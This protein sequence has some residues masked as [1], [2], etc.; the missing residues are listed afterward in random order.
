MQHKFIASPTVEEFLKPEDPH[1]SERIASFSLPAFIITI[2]A[3]IIEAVLLNAMVSG[4]IGV[5]LALLIHLIVSAVIFV[6]AV[7]LRP[8]PAARLHLMTLLLLLVPTSA[9]GAAGAILCQLL[10]LIHA[11]FSTPFKEWFQSIF[12]SV[13]LNK[14]EQLYDDLRTGRDE[15]PRNYEVESFMDVMRYGTDDQKRRALSK[16]T[17]YF[18]PGFAPVLQYALADKSNMIRVQAATATSIIESRFEARLMELT[19]LLKRYP[20]HPEVIL[21]VAEFYDD[22]SFTKILDS[23]REMENQNQ[24]KALYEKC[25]EKDPNNP[26]LIQ[27]Y[28]RLLLRLGHTEEAT[29][30]FEQ[31]FNM[32]ASASGVAWLVECYYRAGRFVSLRQL[33]ASIMAQHGELYDSL[34]EPVRD[35]LGSWA[36]EARP[37]EGG[38]AAAL[39]ASAGGGNH[40]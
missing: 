32:H 9:L 23:E 1:E 10:T 35:A 21:A 19:N 28:G 36:P 17:M 20:D 12:P 7:V 37:F 40:G 18:S 22:F 27:R 39:G 13:D 15:A 33:A 31:L 8:L 2:I 25:L 16:V 29:N 4:S 11:M 14:P 24:A 38:D 26:E 3:F 30:R 5:A 34:Y 6:L